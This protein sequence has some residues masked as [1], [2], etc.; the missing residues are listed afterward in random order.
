MRSLSV[1]VLLALAATVMLAGCGGNS[2]SPSVASLGSPATTTS[3]G[4]GGGTAGGGGTGP[5]NGSQLIMKM[6]DGARFSACMRAHGV[7]N[8]P[9]P[10]SQGTIQVG[11]SSGI[12]PGSPT[13]Q[14]AQSACR[15]LLPNGGQPTPQQVA[16]MQHQALAFSA[17]MRKHGL[18]DFPDPTFTGHGIR[19]AI[20]GGPGSDLNPQ[21]PAFQAAR[22][23]CQDKLPGKIAAGVAGAK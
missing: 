21:S 18:P 6:P 20:R 3:A 19:M 12:D 5:S 23:A 7:K 16:Q 22:Q 2:N 11:P 4:D 1:A 9:D 8:F 10:G 14:A 17:C 13:F 15:K